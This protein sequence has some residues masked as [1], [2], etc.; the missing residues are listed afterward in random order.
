ML[1]RPACD[2]GR[3][4]GASG[5]DISGD[6][7]ILGVALARREVGGGVLARPPLKKSAPAPPLSVSLPSPP[8]SRSLPA[9][10]LSV[11]FP[12]RPK[13]MSG[14]PVPLRVSFFV[15]PTST[16]MVAWRCR[17]AHRSP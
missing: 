12:P 8:T 16:V 6:R 3:Y 5:I 13:I 9:P 11:S 10:P 1:P 14:P 2:S 4:A 7:T 17:R 15:V